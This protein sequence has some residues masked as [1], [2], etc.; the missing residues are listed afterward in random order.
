MCPHSW[1]YTA[2][3]QRKNLTECGG[4]ALVEKQWGLTAAHCE[5]LSYT[6]A[7]LTLH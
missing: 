3:M 7:I 6:G 1:P 5:E 2:A 4:G